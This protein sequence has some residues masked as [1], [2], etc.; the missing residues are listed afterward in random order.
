MGSVIQAVGVTGGGGLV[1]KKMNFLDYENFP[2]P[3]TKP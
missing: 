2:F 3:L 1:L